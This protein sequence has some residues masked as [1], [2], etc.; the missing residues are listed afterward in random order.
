MIS[1][2]RSKQSV[3]AA[4]IT[5]I[6]VFGLRYNQQTH[7]PCIMVLAVVPGATCEIRIIKFRGQNK[8]K[9]H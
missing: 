9:L 7:C 1:H 3:R 6:D 4:L 8:S 5:S 2:S